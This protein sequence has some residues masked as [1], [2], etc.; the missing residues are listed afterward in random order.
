MTCYLI[1]IVCWEQ[2]ELAFVHL[3]L[4]QDDEWFCYSLRIISLFFFLKMEVWVQLVAKHLHRGEVKKEENASRENS[5]KE[6]GKKRKEWG[7]RRKLDQNRRGRKKQQMQC[8]EES[9]REGG[10]EAREEKGTGAGTGL[11]QSRLT[12]RAI[13]P[14]SP[15]SLLVLLLIFPLTQTGW[16]FSLCALSCACCHQ[17]QF[18]YTFLRSVRGSRAGAG[19]GVVMLGRSRT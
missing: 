4:R 16:T 12:L 7:S 6:K 2:N 5:R 18:G 14:S 10:G 11:N 1:M 19:A 3:S 17:E 13:Y 15:P 9:K 8:D